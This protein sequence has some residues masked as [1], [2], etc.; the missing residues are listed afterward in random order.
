MNLRFKPL[1]DRQP[2][3]LITKKSNIKGSKKTRTI[4]CA[5]QRKIVRE[6]VV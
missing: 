5:P 2:K 4:F 6:N 1:P 3:N